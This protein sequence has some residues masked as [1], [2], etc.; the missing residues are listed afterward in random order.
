MVIQPFCNSGHSPWA[1]GRGAATRKYVRPKWYTEDGLVGAIKI[2]DKEL[3]IDMK[4]V[5]VL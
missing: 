4:H 1:Q 3:P 5:Q 2:M